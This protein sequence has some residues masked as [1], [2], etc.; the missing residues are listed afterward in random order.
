M[1]ER[2]ISPLRHAYAWD[3][4]LLPR[5]WSCRRGREDSSTCHKGS[6][7]REALLRDLVAILAQLVEAGVPPE[8]V[9]NLEDDT[10][11]SASFFFHRRAR[12]EGFETSGRFMGVCS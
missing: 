5:T 12:A 3:R 4:T 9:H 10:L 1:V 8:Q 2:R 11:V 6:L 7:V